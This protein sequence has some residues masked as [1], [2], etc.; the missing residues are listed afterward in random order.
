VKK[1]QNKGYYA[2]QSHSRSSR[3]V[4]IESRMRL[5]II[6]KWI[7]TDILSHTVS[8]LSQLT[9]QILNNLRFWAHLCGLRDNVRCSF[10]LI[11]KRV[12]DFLLVLIEHFS[13]G[14]SAEALWAK[15]DRKLAISLQRGQFDLKIR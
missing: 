12:V 5:P 3:S 13:L 6:V 10:E 15:M 4:S 7:V 8:E 11:G 14:V 9:V 1:T 2:V